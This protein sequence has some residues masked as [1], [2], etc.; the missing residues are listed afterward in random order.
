ME[1]SRHS[2]TF[3]TSVP[4]SM[5]MMPAAFS[6][7]VA[8]AWHSGISPNV[9]ARSIGLSMRSHLSE[10]LSLVRTTSLP[11][12]LSAMPLQDR[13]FLISSIAKVLC[14][15]ST[16]ASFYPKYI[17]PNIRHMSLMKFG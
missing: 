4:V 9:H 15:A 3:G 2:P 13:R 17:N 5:A 12:S 14:S 7:V 16:S 11:V 6:P 10:A 8:T 1:H